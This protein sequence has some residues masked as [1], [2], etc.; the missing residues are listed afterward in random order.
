M[1]SRLLL[2][3][4]IALALG[5][6]G[7]AAH[8]STT[9][10]HA[11][12]IE[13]IGD[14]ELATMRGR[15]TV[16]NNTVAWFGVQMISTWQDSTGRVLQGAMN[17]DMDFTHDANLPKVTFVPT[18]SIVQTTQPA[19]P[20]EATG[21]TRST[22]SS[23]LANASGMVQSVQVAGDNN[24]ASNTTRLTVQNGGSVPAAP[25]TAVATTNQAPSAT[26]QSGNAT[27]SANY[28]GNSAQVMLSIAGQGAVQQWIRNGSLGQTVTLAAD[29]QFVSNQ[30]EITL[31]RQA[32]T[33][34]TQLALDVAR[35]IQSTRGLGH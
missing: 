24:A 26:V 20:Q 28:T 6:W 10:Q 14:A 4:S 16:G 23:G 5:H 2:L 18:V 22:D 8:A 19:A 30:M 9:A 35:S 33:A 7:T 17:L 1:N 25:A 34:N 21:P 15:Y 3:S 31:I 13:P 11:S 32:I 29:N 12:G 27:V